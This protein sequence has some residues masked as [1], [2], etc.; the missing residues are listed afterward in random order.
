MGVCRAATRVLVQISS[1]LHSFESGTPRLGLCV[2]HRDLLEAVRQD[3]AA[4]LT[5]MSGIIFNTASSKA[6]WHVL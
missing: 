3:I 1:L 5:A 6:S 4:A 2:R